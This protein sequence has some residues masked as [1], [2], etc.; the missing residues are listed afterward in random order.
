MADDRLL[1]MVMVFCSGLAMLASWLAP[2]RW[3]AWL[4]A[5][6]GMLMLGLWSPLSLGLLGVAT[7][8]SYAL[9]RR[10]PLRKSQLVAAVLVVAGTYWAC[11]VLG[12]H[13][14]EGI[15]ASIVLPLGMAFY[16]L[17]LIHC[18]FESYKGGLRQFS[19]ADYLSYHFFPAALPV[20]PIHRFD[21]FLRDLRR[22]R[23]D[24]ALF[25][26][27]LERI[28]YG[29]FRLVVVGNVLIDV[30]LKEAAEPLLQTPGLT[31]YYVSALLFWLKLYIMFSG[32]SEVAIGFGNLMGFQLRE[33]FNWP[34][35]A[36]NISEFWQRWHMSLSSW[37]RDYVFTPVL[38]GT[39]QPWVAVLS[40]MIVLGLWHELSLRYLL[41]GVYHGVG[42]AVQRWFSS[43]A[44]PR[45][46]HWTGFASLSLRV[47]A[48]LLTLHFVLFSFQIT[49]ALERLLTGG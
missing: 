1:L 29:V 39:R 14:R 32:F 7:L 34:F 46:Q 30:K 37:C 43:Y 49:Y 26:A 19:L 8:G 20:G 23:W 12:R 48:T 40:S 33:N 4:V 15:G 35:A 16:S 31:G 28:L 27:G 42:I 6:C 47:A 25:S 24:S 21:E 44:G 36:R 11:M 22:R 41:W 5:L 2:P 13:A 17:R 18:L 38:A 45:T 10:A 9:L 3:Q